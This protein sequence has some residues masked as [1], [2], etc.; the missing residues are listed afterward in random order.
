M[1]GVYSLAGDYAFPRQPHKLTSTYSDDISAEEAL[2]AATSISDLKLGSVGL[3][4]AGLGAVIL[5]VQILE[6]RQQ[7]W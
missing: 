3:V 5:V 2:H 6:Q 7:R 4:C 1:A